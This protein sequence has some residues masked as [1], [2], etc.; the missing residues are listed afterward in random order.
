VEAPAPG[1]S[2]PE[3]YLGAARADRFANGR[4]ARGTHAFRAPAELPSDHLAYGGRWRIAADSATAVSG[5]RL[6]VAF[7]ARRVYLVLGSEGGGAHRA[8]VLLDGRPLP[9]RLAGRDVR[10]GAVTVRRQ[11]LYRL[12]DLR[13]A[14]R[15]RLTLQLTPG[16]SGYAFTFG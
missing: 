9:D 12:V 10:S 6:D 7:G 1:V 15:H 13:R 8:R 16:I 2:T 3:S 11:R 4:I 14:E 5:A